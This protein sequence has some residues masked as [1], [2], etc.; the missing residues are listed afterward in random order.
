MEKDKFGYYSYYNTRK[1]SFA[2]K[3]EAKDFYDWLIECEKEG[4]VENVSFID[5]AK[6]R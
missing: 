4:L 5:N 2:T 3:K 1:E 6:K